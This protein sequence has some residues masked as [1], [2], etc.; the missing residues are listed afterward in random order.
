M[1]KRRV[2]EDLISLLIF[3]IDLFSAVATFSKKIFY[4]NLYKTGFGDL[5]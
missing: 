2:E 1:L 4:R 5:W 3:Y